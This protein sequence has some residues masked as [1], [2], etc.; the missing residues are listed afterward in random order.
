MDKKIPTELH[1]VA[2]E[3]LD[4]EIQE[5][6]EIKDSEVSLGTYIKNTLELTEE[7]IEEAKDG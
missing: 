6:L 2:S 4:K 1:A 7:E 5:E 3:D